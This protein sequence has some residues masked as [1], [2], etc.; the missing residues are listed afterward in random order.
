L[1]ASPVRGSALPAA[2]DTLLHSLLAA[3]L[4]AVDAERCVHQAA[5]LVAPLP[6]GP[7]AV[8][9]IGKAAAG[10]A[11]GL[12]GWL[13]AHNVA[14]C[15]G[16]VVAHTA[17]V[18]PHPAVPVVIGDHPV[19]GAAS[20]RAATALAATIASLPVDAAVHVAIS[21]GT[22]ALV[23]APRD[24]IDAGVFAAE[25]RALLD[26]GLP[27]TTM[28]Q[29]RRAIARFA[30]GGLAEAL[31]PRRTTGWLLSDVVGGPIAAI[32][33]GPLAS[34]QVAVPMH[35]VGDNAMAVHAAAEAAR[36]Q[37]CAVRVV[38]E[39]L[40]GEAADAGRAIAATFLATTPTRIPQVLL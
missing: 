1:G 19:P 36:A 23:G 8:L 21:G 2:P 33:S 34:P 3:A 37:G 35:L 15:G 11:R 17:V 32:G 9:A 18:P 28:N 12:V 29:R 22:S 20:H 27:I 40:G 7:T 16:L 39:Q 25:W 31:A 4:D 5:E 24:G 13:A 10:M 14:P 6:E 26:A 30:G 38:S